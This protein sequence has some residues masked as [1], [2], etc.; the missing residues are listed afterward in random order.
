MEKFGSQVY[1]LASGIKGNNNSLRMVTLSQLEDLSAEKKIVEQIDEG[2]AVIAKS[3]E[4]LEKIG[5][6]MQEQESKIEELEK[7][8]A[9]LK[10]E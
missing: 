1:G 3:A 9:E 6:A 5:L 2:F 10:K 4:D 8:L 7:E